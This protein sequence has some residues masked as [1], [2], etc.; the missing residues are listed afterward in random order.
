[1][2]PA[3]F[4]AEVFAENV[5]NARSMALGPQGTVFVGSQYV[6][7]VHAVVDRDGDHKA[8]RVVMIASGLNQPN[9]VAMRNG[10]L[11]VATTSRILRFDDIEKHLD[12]PPKP[13]TVRDN[14]PNPKPGHTWK[15][16]AFGPDDMLYM[17][18]GAPCNVCVPPP[19]GRRRSCG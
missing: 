14:L 4:Q 10:A 17:S 5:D 12:A 3:G 11:Y 19:H 18:V 13:V 7:K 16:I 6:G 1:M 15:F 8:D 9:G 2:V